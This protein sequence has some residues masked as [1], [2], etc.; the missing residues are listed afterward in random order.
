MDTSKELSW[1]INLAQNGNHEDNVELA[2]GDREVACI[3]LRI[4]DIT[5]SGRLHLPPHLLE[6]FG[7]HIQDLKVAFRNASGHLNAE[8]PG[9]GSELEHAEARG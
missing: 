8:V 3:S 2:V 1:A 9:A 4:P 7:L 6:H 5:H